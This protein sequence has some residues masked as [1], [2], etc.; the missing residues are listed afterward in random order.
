MVKYLMGLVSVSDSKCQAGYQNSG[1]MDYWREKN[2]F[3]K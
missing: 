1:M 2:T 3:E